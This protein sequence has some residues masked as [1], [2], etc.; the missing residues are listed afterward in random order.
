MK[1]EYK[2]NSKI[3]ALVL[4]VLVML[5]S[6]CGCSGNNDTIYISFGTGTT[7][8]VFYTAGIG[9]G[10][11]LEDKTKMN[12][13]VEATKA[14]AEN[15]N[16]LA[17]GDIEIATASFPTTL[18]GYTGDGSWSNDPQDINV[19]FQMYENPMHVFVLQDSDIYTMQ[20]LRGKRISVGQA[21][22]GNY[23][24]AVALLEG[25]YGLVEGVDYTPEYLS[26]SESSEAFKNGIIDAAVFDTVSPHATIIDIASWKPVRLIPVREEDLQNVGNIYAQQF[27]PVIIPEGTYKGQEEDVLCA[28]H[29]NYVICSGNLD[30]EIAYNV[31]KTVMENLDYMATVHDALKQ[32]NL[33]N[34]YFSG[35]LPLHPGA[36]KYYEEQGISLENE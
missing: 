8:G 6:L 18:Q 1:G 13:T 20:D 15:I 32:L 36:I 23:N 35:G 5:F 11:L 21:G 24:S 3:P 34:A 7:G 4:C 22:S 28:A 19:L 10:T 16:L 25:V 12:V 29:G 9:I 27:M 17:N 33:D 30:E 26:Y 31:V 2:S 14:S